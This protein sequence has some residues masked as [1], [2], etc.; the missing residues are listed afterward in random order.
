MHIALISENFDTDFPDFHKV[1][2]T[3][4][5]DPKPSTLN[6]KESLG[7]IIPNILILGQLSVSI[8]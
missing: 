4:N 3:I 8:A 6:H 7:Y 2:I 1:S 5:C